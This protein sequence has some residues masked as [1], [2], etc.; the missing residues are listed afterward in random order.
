MHQEPSHRSLVGHLA[1]LLALCGCVPL[2][3]ADYGGDCYYSY[4]ILATTCDEVTSVCNINDCNT[5]NGALSY[6]CYDPYTC[7]GSYTVPAATTATPTTTTSSSS[8]GSGADRADACNSMHLSS[9][10]KAESAFKGVGCTCYSCVETNGNIEASCTVPF[11]CSPL[12]SNPQ[13]ETSDAPEMGDGDYGIVCAVY[14]ATAIILGGSAVFVAHLCFPA[15]IKETSVKQ[16]V[17]QRLSAF[18]WCIY[19]LA[20]FA[21]FVQDDGAPVAF[22]DYL[23]DNNELLGLID[24]RKK[25]AA[26]RPRWMRACAIAAAF[27]VTLSLAYLL[28]TVVYNNESCQSIVTVNYCRTCAC[29]T[30]CGGMDIGC[31]GDC[32]C[33]ANN[34]CGGRYQCSGASSEVSTSATI[35]TSSFKCRSA[36]IETSRKANW[37]TML[38]TMVMSK[39]SSIA[40]SSA[41]DG[42]WRQKLLHLAALLV[43]TALVA[44]GVA[45]SKHL[46]KPENAADRDASSRRQQAI[47]QTLFTGWW[48]DQLAG[49]VLTLGQFG[50]FRL[51]YGTLYMAKVEE[52]KRTGAAA[53]H[54][55]GLDDSIMKTDGVKGD[56]G[57]PVTIE[58]VTLQPPTQ[59]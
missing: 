55:H 53:V 56:E 6:A 34:G 22:I 51:C 57:R 44:F 11:E 16:T 13:D 25:T 42:S 24:W 14:I 20:S 23:C 38:L 4:G 26:V 37:T 59:Q 27:L 8:A 12:T 39:A 1:V 32:Q 46:S 43:S 7:S 40:I 52:A 3:R 58:Q 41:E 2:A 17:K 49:L 48:Y 19:T 29:Q 5:T 35:T 31:T 10:T 54:P 45:Y 15:N 18:A 47:G 28:G 9:C 50:V 33:R 36:S 21:S 30:I